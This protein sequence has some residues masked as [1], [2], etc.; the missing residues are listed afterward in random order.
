MSWSFL[1]VGRDFWKS[2]FVSQEMYLDMYTDKYLEVILN[3][4]FKKIFSY[5]LNVF[6][7][8]LLTKIL[9]L[10]SSTVG[11]ESVF[12]IASPINSVKMRTIGR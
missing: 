2:L 7:L 4:I 6:H 11:L 10:L 8:I 1:R 3:N 5:F 12:L 9:R